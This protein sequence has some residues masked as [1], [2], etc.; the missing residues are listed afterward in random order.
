MFA[1]EE[2]SKNASVAE[3][4]GVLVPRVKSLELRGE[5]DDTHLRTLGYSTFLALDGRLTD[6]MTIE[7]YIQGH[8]VGSFINAPPKG[9]RPNCKYS[10]Q[11]WEGS[12]RHYVLPDGKTVCVQQRVFVQALRKIA[13]GEELFVAYGP[14]YA[15]LH[16]Q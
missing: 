2:I 10:V 4:W 6:S 16:L 7:K 9:V 11:T 13:P 1:V 12:S 8:R 3:Y 5:L 15:S 14:T